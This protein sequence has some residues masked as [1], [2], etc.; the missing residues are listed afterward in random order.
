M[1]LL[2][3]I[4]FNSMIDTPHWNNYNKAAMYVVMNGVT[5]KD[6]N[7]LGIVT[8]ANTQVIGR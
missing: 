5:Y 8:I 2:N 6:R 4:Q 7:S 1:P 3:S